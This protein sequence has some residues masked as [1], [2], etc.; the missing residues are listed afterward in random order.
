VL[1]EH[2]A[3]RHGLRGQRAA[4]GQALAQLRETG[5]ARRGRCVA[6]DLVAA[7]HDISVDVSAVLQVEPDRLVDEREDRSLPSDGSLFPCS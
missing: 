4:R 1:V 7:L 6:L 2:E 3:D 5:A